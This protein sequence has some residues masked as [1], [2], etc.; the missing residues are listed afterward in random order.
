MHN[1]AHPFL[2][3]HILKVLKQLLGGWTPGGTASDWA[4]GTPA[5]PVITGVANGTKCWIVHCRG[6]LSVTVNANNSCRATATVVITE[7]AALAHTVFTHRNDLTSFRYRIDC[8][9]HRMD[10]LKN[11]GELGQVE[12]SGF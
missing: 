2:F 1:L 8:S 10:P 12:R 9:Q 5:K 4:W 7:P 6:H 3:F 11:S